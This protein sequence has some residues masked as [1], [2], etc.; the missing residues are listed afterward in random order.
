VIFFL[1]FLLFGADM[2]LQLFGRIRR[3][4]R[5]DVAFVCVF[6]VILFVYVAAATQVI[7]TSKVAWIIAQ[8]FA[9][10]GICLSRIPVGVAFKRALSAKRN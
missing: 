4:G 9:L 2:L 1:A 8:Y 5:D 3:V 7:G 6:I 10:A